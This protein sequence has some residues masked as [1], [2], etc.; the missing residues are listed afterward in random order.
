ML[1]RETIVINYENHEEHTDALRG[2]NKEFQN[3][4]SGEHL[5]YIW[6]SRVKINI[7]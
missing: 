1:F 7:K 6:L 3:V 2:Q 4:K 5:V